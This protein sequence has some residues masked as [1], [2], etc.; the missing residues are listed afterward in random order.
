[1]REVFL[2][3]RDLNGQAICFVARHCGVNSQ[4]ILAVSLEDPTLSDFFVWIFSQLLG[5][6]KLFVLRGE[7]FE[8]YL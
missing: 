2:F 3:S 8:G 1:M 7:L 5:A 4:T 6:S